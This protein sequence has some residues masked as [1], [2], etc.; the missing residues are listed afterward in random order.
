MPVRGV[1][2]VG[3]RAVFQSVSLHGVRTI[4]RPRIGS[5]P[6]SGT[7]LAFLRAASPT[8]TRRIEKITSSRAEPPTRSLSWWKM[9][10]FAM[11]RPPE[12]PPGATI[13]T[14]G[15]LDDPAYLPP[16]APSPGIA[17]ITR[18]ADR[19]RPLG[20]SPVH[21]RTDQHGEDQPGAGGKL[22]RL[23]CRPRH[24][25]HAEVLQR[26]P[27]PDG[28]ADRQRGPAAPGRLE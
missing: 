17:G 19:G 7:G 20:R 25:R 12:R 22:G 10:A 14:H 2:T 6:G 23:P 27:E 15:G 18:A 5:L 4:F 8:M 3:R 16:S 1:R 28:A 9:V 24:P 21:A 26:R 11:E 13:D